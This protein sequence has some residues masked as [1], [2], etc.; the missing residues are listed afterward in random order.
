MTVQDLVETP[1][2]YVLV[3]YMYNT[4]QYRINITIKLH[5]TIT[6]IILLY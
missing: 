6:T 3:Q 1:T 4:V 5:G 2:L